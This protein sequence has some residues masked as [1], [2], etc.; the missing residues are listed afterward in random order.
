MIV[1]LLHSPFYVLYRH[2]GFF[3]AILSPP[4]YYLNCPVQL[5]C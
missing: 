3:S 1:G 4:S 2:I 5:P